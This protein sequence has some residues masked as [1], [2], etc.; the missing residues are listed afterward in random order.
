MKAVLITDQHFGARN[1]SLQILEHQKKF[2]EETFFPF[3]N[4]TKIT[5]VITLGDFFDHRKYTNNY[6]YNF[7]LQKFIFLVNTDIITE[8]MTQYMEI[9]QEI[10]YL[11]EIGIEYFNLKNDFYNMQ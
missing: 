5:T 8:Y 6:I 7:K 2:Y 4:A 9:I 1:N 10:K 3:L 11:P